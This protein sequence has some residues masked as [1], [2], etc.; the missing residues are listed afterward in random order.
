MAKKQ[1]QQSVSP[2]S[3]TTVT[4]Y[5]CP[6]VTGYQ[7]VTA[8]SAAA[9]TVGAAG[10]DSVTRENLF[11]GLFSSQEECCWDNG[12][13]LHS[14]GPRDITDSSFDLSYNTFPLVLR[15]AEFMHRQNAT[16]PEKDNCY[17]GQQPET[18]VANNLSVASSTAFPDVWFEKPYF[19][20]AA[21]SNASNFALTSSSSSFYGIGSGTLASRQMVQGADG[22]E[23]DQDGRMQEQQVVTA[24]RRSSLA[25]ESLR[26][27]DS[28]GSKSG[29]TRNEMQ[30]PSTSST[31][32]CQLMS[33]VYLRF[34]AGSSTSSH[35]KCRL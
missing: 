6:T 7:C 30:C 3:R 1:R 2:E 10:K 18:T 31:Y 34:N 9:A 29:R 19:A 11:G 23:D 13:S 27:N 5:Q 4:G 28:S 14:F 26:V 25:A 21:S 12:T 24:S 15:P 22:K 16:Q 32:Q 8:V 33:S 17:T 35:I 20:N